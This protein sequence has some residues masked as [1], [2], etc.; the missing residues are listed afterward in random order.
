V[1]RVTADSTLRGRIAAALLARIRQAT[2][3]PGTPLFGGG[4]QHVMAAN[5]YDLADVVLPIVATERAAAY[6]DA[7]T[8]ADEA[9]ATYAQR[10]DHDQAGVAF[11]VMEQ[12]AAKAA[13]CS[14]PPCNSEETCAQHAHADVTGEQA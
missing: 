7:A 13:G 12:L 6:R 10:G 11:A 5:E 14:W 2:V 1:D 9:G 8:V 4:M 3:Q